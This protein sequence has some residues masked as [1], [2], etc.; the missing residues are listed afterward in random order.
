MSLGKKSRHVLPCP[1][2]NAHALRTT[3]TVGALPTSHASAVTSPSGHWCARLDSEL[4]SGG[5]NSRHPTRGLHERD[6]SRHPPDHPAVATAHDA[7]ADRMKRRAFLGWLALDAVSCLAITS[8]SSARTP[9]VVVVGVTP[10]S[11]HLREAFSGSLADAGYTE[12]RNATIEYRDVDGRPELL[13]QLAEAIGRSDVDV[14]FA[15]GGGAVAAMKKASERIPIVAVD[16]ESDP[17]AAG[18]VQ[19]LAKPGGNITGVFLDLPEVSGKQL[20][21]LREI[22]GPIA[23]I[24][25]VGDPVINAPQFQATESAA[26]ALTIQTQALPLRSSSDIDAIIET[27]HKGR[28]NAILLLSS[29]I[30]FY[31]RKRLG[32]LTAKR[33]LPTVSMFSEFAQAGGLMAYGPSLREAFRLAGARVGRIL[34]GANP[35]DLPVERPAKFELLI[36]A[37]TAKALRLTIPP[38]VLARAERVIE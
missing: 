6:G 19:S 23:R 32:E 15:R 28:A 38:S 24:A 11:Q 29:P 26:R 1:A 14:V 34:Q 5:P 37:K 35:G 30:V 13:P 27:A 16:L 8:Q 21:L 9:R 20:Q 18:F 33:S 25:I 2:E 10:I 7:R 31:H 22:I 17:V 4:D 36:N 3:E 12:G